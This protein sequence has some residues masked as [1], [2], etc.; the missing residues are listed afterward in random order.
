MGTATFRHLDLVTLLKVHGGE[1]TM[2]SE[3]KTPL[4]IRKRMRSSMAL[5]VNSMGR[6]DIQDFVKMI[7]AWNTIGNQWPS[8]FI[9]AGTK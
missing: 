4:P 2:L 8:N 9:T 1:Q 5:Q 7:Y 3:P 6:V